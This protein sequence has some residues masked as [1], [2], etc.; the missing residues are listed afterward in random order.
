M[1]KLLT[2]IYLFV[3]TCALTYFIGV[4]SGVACVAQISDKD[5]VGLLP[6]AFTVLG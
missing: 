2:S 3:E 4:E 1:L 5:V 6:F